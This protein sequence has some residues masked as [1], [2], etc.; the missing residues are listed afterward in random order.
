[1]KKFLFTILLLIVV[2][3]P[4]FSQY[5]LRASMGI[6]YASMPSL[7]DYINQ[8]YAP[9]GN[10]LN[11]FNSAI[12]FSAE[13]GYLVNKHYQV[14][15]ELGYLINS[16][17][18]TFFPTKY[19]FAY[20]IFMPSVLNYYVLQGKGYKF[21]FGGG[22]GLRF[23]SVHE[24]KP[25]LTKTYNYR[26]VGYGLILRAE[27]NTLLSGNFYVSLGGDIRYD[28][29]GEPKN[30]N[31]YIVNNGKKVSLSSFSAGVRLGITYIF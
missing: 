29:N 4:S 12:E 26:S 1:M 28:I 27:G 10:Q 20:N 24:T 30:G 21:K 9:A 31:N 22:L 15:F 18:Y 23:S 2:S 14:G 13:A 16:F 7:V 8:S 5:E 25:I 11:S 19:E 3:K 17:T 6:D